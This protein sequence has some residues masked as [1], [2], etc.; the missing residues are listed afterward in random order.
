MP[1]ACCGHP[2]LHAAALSL[3]PNLRYCLH[4][5]WCLGLAALLLSCPAAGAFTVLPRCPAAEPPQCACLAAC[6]GALGPA[7]C[8]GG[9]WPDHHRERCDS[10]GGQARHSRTQETRELRAHWVLLPWAGHCREWCYPA[11]GHAR[12]GEA[13]CLRVVN[14]LPSHVQTAG[15]S[16]AAAYQR[17]ELPY[18]ALF[19]LTPSNP[20]SMQVLEQLQPEP[21]MLP[22]SGSAERQRAA[23]LMRLERQLFSAWLQWLCNGW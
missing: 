12:G 9:G 2:A 22:P 18:A 13:S 5:Y 7:A 3:A 6:A 16:A 10:A 15:V 14:A 4:Y 11:G 17:P 23:E 1:H 8:A 19:A 21:A 20:H